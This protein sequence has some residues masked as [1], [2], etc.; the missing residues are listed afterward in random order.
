M[1]R[2]IAQLKAWF[3]RG[4]YPTEEQFA[5]WMDSYVHKEESEIPISQVGN[6]TE[7]LNGK[8]AATAGQELERQH[9]RLKSDYE[10][11]KQDSE[12][13]FETIDGDIDRLDG[14]IA[15]ETER[16]TDEEVKIRKEFAAADEKEKARAT[17]EETKLDGKIGAET[18]RA[19][20][21][22][23][24]LQAAITVEQSRATE[25]ETAIRA[26]M[27]NGDNSTLD[28]A[29]K[30]ADKKVA[31]LV[32][33]APKTLDTLNELAEALNND[34]N[35]AA[36]VSA[37]IGQKVDKAE[38]KGLSTEDYTTAEKNKLKGI[39]EKANN[40]THPATH[41]ADMIT[42]TSTKVV[43]TK[44]ERDKLAGI[45]AGANAYS[46]PASHPATMIVEDETH[47]FV[48]ATEKNTWNAKAGKSTTLSGYGITDAKIAEGTITLGANSIKPLTEKD[49]T[50]YAKVTDIPGQVD[51]SGYYKKTDKV[52]NATTAD[53]VGS[54]TVGG[55]DTPVYIKEGVPAVVNKVK[56]AAKADQLESE[57]IP[58]NADLN[59]YTTPG[60][61]YH[62]IYNSTA[63]TLSN[64]PTSGIAFSMFTQ[65]VAGSTKSTIQTVVTYQENNSRKIYQRTYNSDSK[66]WGEWCRIYTTIDKP[67]A[68]D[69]GAA[70]SS[71]TH[72]AENI[73]S[74]TLNIARIPTGTTESTVAKGNHKHTKS[75]ITDFPAIPTAL[76]NPSALTFTGAVSQS[77]DG[78]K[79]VTV[80]IPRGGTGL[81]EITYA[82][83]VTRRNGGTLIPGTLYRITDYVTAVANDP[84]A[85]S[86]K[87]PFD[88]IVLATAANTLSEE[89]R[90]IKHSG[91]SYFAKADLN[92]WKLWYCLDNDTTRFQWADKTS[93][94]GVVYRLIDEWGNDCPYDFKNVQFKRYKV[95]ATD[96]LTDLNGTYV[97]IGGATLKGLTASESDYIW[98]YTFSAG[99]RK[100]KTAPA[101]GSLTGLGG[102]TSKLY[103]G[104]NILLPYSSKKTV[105]GTS[106]NIFCLNN[107][108]WFCAAS[109]VMYGNR[110]G[111]ECYN[112]TLSSYGNTFGA[113]C[114][115]N[116]F[117]NYFQYNTF[118]NYCNNNTFGNSC[119]NNTFGNS[120]TNNTFGNSC[121]GNTFGNYC[122]NSTFGNSCYYNT[123]G[124]SCYG[125]TF[126]NNCYS[127]TFGSGCYNNT[128][129][130]SCYGNTFG[131]YCYNSTF[132][133]YC[134]NSTF[135]NYCYNNTFG[136]YLRYLTINDGVQYVNVTGGSSSSSYVQ[137]AQV[138]NGTA[139]SSTSSRLTIT[140]TANAGYCQFAGK[141]TSGTLKIWTPAN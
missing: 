14:L 39:A 79:A 15:D 72:S 64:C 47:K 49:L 132:G 121:Y 136:N 119:T 138:L 54:A 73:T 28:A 21:V 85:Q 114:Y 34:P 26:D 108:V 16:A 7:Q 55:A 99:D 70:A 117:G 48:T 115:N 97:G 10:T 24:Q 52:A 100:T 130:N 53:K 35:F 11:H 63:K 40:Y 93:G 94:K 107:I 105:D 103:C 116:T 141:T 92:A 50:G 139:G 111:A 1:I 56:A 36:T 6:L 134:Y 42:D 71:H 46:H 78:S 129:G 91:D 83:L 68:A 38:G 30:Y 95:T 31:G 33:S 51:L 69:V 2:S 41:A 65:S 23:G 8:Y 88:I 128:F 60:K 126:G 77:Y 75:E 74:G 67:T 17:A 4:K 110:V 106:S 112:M 12:A 66:A 3:R 45:A 22:E 82:N 59:T 96:N 102:S 90:A 127:N 86:A 98:A 133:N 137:N 9:N 131:N 61:L 81:E 20:G 101:D 120:C 118:G 13:K 122:Y 37:Q 124:N 18:E 25:E 104:T 29:K 76:K 57:A 84:E 125:N 89:A 113:G 58:E 43:M 80:D 44:A 140:F 123:F 109:E 19:T 5:D 27:T 32:N 135:G 62:C 87:H